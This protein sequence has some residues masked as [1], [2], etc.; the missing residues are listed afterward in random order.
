MKRLLLLLLVLGLSC[1]AQ[2]AVIFDNLDA[3]NNGVDSVSAFGPLADSFSTGAGGFTFASIGLKLQDI[4]DPSGSFTIQLLADNNINP[5]SAIY[6]IATVQDSK[7]TD[8][9]Q[10][11]FFV[12]SQPQI[13]AANTRYWIELSSSD[14]SVANWGWSVDTSGPGVSSE[15]FANISGVFTNNNGAYQMQIS[16]VP[17]PGTLMMLGTGVVGVFGAVRR[18]MMM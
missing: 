2:A 1:G 11:Y 3:S 6:T 4:G 7:L 14:G 15:Y 9:L 18:R 16:D 8:S 12:L 10:D 13:L 17:E 5:G